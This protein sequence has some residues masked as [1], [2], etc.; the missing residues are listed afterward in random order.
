[1]IK[2]L[3]FADIVGRPGRQAIAAALLELRPKY[4]PD[5]VI[6]NVENTTHGFGICKKHFEDLSKLDID[7]MTTGNHIWDQKDVIGVLENHPEKMIRPGN[8]P[9][10]EDNPCPGSGLTYFPLKQPLPPICVINLQ[11]RVFM[12]PID[13]PFQWLE[14][15]LPE[16][17]S[18]TSLIFVDF[19]AQATSEKLAFGHFFDG[20]V[21]AIVGTHTHVQT[22]DETILPKGTAYITD[23]GMCGSHT[24][25]I[26]M[27]PEGSIYRIRMKRPQ[28]LTVATE[29]IMANAVAI[30]VD[31][32]TGKAEAIER[33]RIHV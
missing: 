5:V 12:D 22:S 31:E 1:M 14:Q 33:I 23:V 29:T 9:S 10:F 27:E 18:Q 32:Q 2:I 28:R 3:F 20:Q 4:S 17:Q 6:V 16:I 15:M 25:V 26:G 7:V 8:Y 19:H 21:S 30:T 24:S 11:G 13:C